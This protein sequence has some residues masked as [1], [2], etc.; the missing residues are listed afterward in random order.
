M[1]KLTLEASLAD[2][3]HGLLARL[4]GGWSGSTKTWFEPD[5]LAD[6]SKFEGRFSP[7]LDGRF[8]AFEYTA[9][10]SGKP[11]GGRAWYG[12]HLDGGEFTKAWIDSF[13]TNT[14]MMTFTGA[15]IEGGFEVA[16]TYAAGDG[17]PWGWRSRVVLSGDD[18]LVITDFNVTPDGEAARAIETALRRR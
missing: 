4:V 8:V 12:Y 6:E 1:A 2:G 10:L 9:E 3:P 11:R 13:H 16:G 14:S 18:N 7:L 15:A 5:K 17:P